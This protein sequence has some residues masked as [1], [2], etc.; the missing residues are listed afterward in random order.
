MDDPFITSVHSFTEI[1]E[2]SLILVLFEMDD[3]FMK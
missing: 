1:R 2:Q 3:H